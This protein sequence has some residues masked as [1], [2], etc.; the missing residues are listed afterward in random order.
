MSIG[1][2]G[3]Y[4]P[5]PAPSEW[6]VVGWSDDPVRGGDL[7]KVTEFRR[8]YVGISETLD[9]AVGRLD[10][11]VSQGSEGLAG[12]YAEGLREDA[13]KVRE[14]LSKAAVR[15]GDVAR[16]VTT[17]EPELDHALTE[18]RAGLADA[19]AGADALVAAE[20][21]PDGKPDEEGVLDPD[22][23][24]KDA[25]KRDRIATAGD[26]VSAA[27]R[28][29]QTAF[30]RLQ[31]AGKRLGDAVNCKNYDDG[32]TDSTWDKVLAVLKIVSKVLAIIAMAL[33][34]LCFLFPGVALLLAASVIVALAAVAVAGILYAKGEEGLPDLLFAIFGVLLLGGATVATL[35]GR[36][37]GNAAR[38]ARTNIGDTLGGIAMNSFGPGGRIMPVIG[39][40][41]AQWRKQSDWFDN[42]LT[43]WLMRAGGRGGL[44][45]EVGFWRSSIEQ[46]STAM[47]MWP[48]LWTSP[49]AFFKEWAGV[50]GGWG[51]YRSIA[52]LQQITG[53]ATNPVWW[54]W[55]V[56]NSIFTIGTGLIWTGGRTEWRKPE[57]SWIPTYGTVGGDE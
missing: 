45:P 53:Q 54:A 38:A 36:S 19:Q 1:Q 28:R 32:L 6:T 14:Q 39:R 16:E 26:A 51:G 35:V 37:I 44:V 42:P 13:G 17:Y 47:K 3:L 18:T 50:V 56:G 15:Y 20:G 7:E 55:G 46:M 12:Q 43:S 11:V 2:Q 57:D 25:Q 9:S 5:T 8:R 30:D 27:K 24:A 10:R 34:I 22:E 52:G 40:N 49:G 31:V 4:F 48:K 41:A 23:T 33:A 29:V 21:L